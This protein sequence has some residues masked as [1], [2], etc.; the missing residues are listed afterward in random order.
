MASTIFLFNKFFV[1][2][3]FTLILAIILGIIVYSILI[4]TLDG[5]FLKAEVKNILANSFKKS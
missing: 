2:S 4:Y 3:L 1:T 5:K